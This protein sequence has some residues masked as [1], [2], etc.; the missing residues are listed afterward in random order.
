MVF[1]EFIEGNFYLFKRKKKAKEGCSK[2]PR[3]SSLSEYDKARFV[4][5][6]AKARFHDSVT[7]RSG[8]KE[9]GFDIDVENTKI[10]DF[11]RIIQSRG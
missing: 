6:D 1:R 7:R 5:I 3:G 2:R 8:L 4:S 11:Q 10:E 9:M